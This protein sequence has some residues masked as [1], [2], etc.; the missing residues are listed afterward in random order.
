MKFPNSLVFTLIL[1]FSLPLYKSALFVNFHS[2]QSFT[3]CHVGETPVTNPYYINS[4][5]GTPENYITRYKMP[6]TDQL[7]MPVP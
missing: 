3:F 5:T 4:G 6:L 2:Q 7:K 1:I